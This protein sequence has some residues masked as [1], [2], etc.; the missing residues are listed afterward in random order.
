MMKKISTFPDGKIYS[1]PARLPSR[2]KSGTQPLINKAW[3]D[4]LGL[5]TPTNVKDLYD[6]LKAIKEQD[7]NGNGKQDEN[8]VSNS[9]DI[10]LNM[11]SIFG[12]T[13]LR[14]NN[15][16]IKDGKPVYYPTSEEY[17]EGFKWMHKLYAEGIID[18]ESFTQDDTC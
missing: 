9:G 8:P 11:H 6:V 13:D 15:M 10:E 16:I 3:L 4:K 18:M 12:I 1:L 14:G 5:E 2:P 17:K 7:P